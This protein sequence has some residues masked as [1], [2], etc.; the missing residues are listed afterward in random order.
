[1][2]RSLLVAFLE[3]IGVTSVTIGAFL[4]SATAGFV[5]FG[6]LSL[7]AAWSASR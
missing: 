7:T 6:A 3:V 5:T 1:M 2:T 4:V